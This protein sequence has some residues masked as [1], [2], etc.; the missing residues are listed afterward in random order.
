[1]SDLHFA[2][3]ENVTKEGKYLVYTSTATGA[4]CYHYKDVAH[5]EDGPALVGD[6]IALYY[7]NGTLYEF[8]DWKAEIRKRKLE[9]LGI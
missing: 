8:D 4:K 5:R 7:L 9:A 1:M 6:G 2:T 3:H